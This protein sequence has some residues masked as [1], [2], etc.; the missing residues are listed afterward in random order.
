[1]L[2]CAGVAGVVPG[3]QVADI[4]IYTFVS[5]VLALKG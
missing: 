3:P 5:I 1:M 4:R 2:R